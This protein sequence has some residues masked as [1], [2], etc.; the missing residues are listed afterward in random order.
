MIIEDLMQSVPLLSED[1]YNENEDYINENEID[2]EHYIDNVDK[3]EYTETKAYGNKPYPLEVDKDYDN[4]YGLLPENY[5][6]DTKMSFKDRMI[7]LFTVFSFCFPIN[8]V[9]LI[10]YRYG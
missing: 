9:F 10:I 6:K 4:P 2:N 5:F 3:I 8:L 7:C 1:Y